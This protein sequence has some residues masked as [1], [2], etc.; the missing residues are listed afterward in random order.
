MGRAW[1][2]ALTVGCHTTVTQ[3]KGKKRKGKD[4]S[5]AAAADDE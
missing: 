4:A 1:D 2:S 3:R 5:V